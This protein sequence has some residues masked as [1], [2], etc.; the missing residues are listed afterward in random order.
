[1]GLFGEGLKSVGLSWAW[2]CGPE[3]WGGKGVP[4]HENWVA[5]FFEHRRK[6]I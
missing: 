5:G 3:L 4:G 2:E 1:M 6:G